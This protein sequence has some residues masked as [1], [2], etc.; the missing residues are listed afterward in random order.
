M[1]TRARHTALLD[2]LMDGRAVGRLA[3]DP[4]ERGAI[5]F[6]YDAQWLKSGY[7]LSPFQPFALKTQAFKPLSKV[8]DG[9]HGVF[10]DALPDGWGLLLMDR[11]LK[12]TLD[13]ERHDIEPLDRQVP[14]Q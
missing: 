4:N 12:R 7:A 9:L 5:W 2:V 11:A 10:N 13:W 14:S 6:Q 1:S 3:Q 8:F